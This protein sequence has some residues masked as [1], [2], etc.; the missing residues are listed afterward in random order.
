MTSTQKLLSNILKNRITAELKKEERDFTS[1]QGTID[2]FIAGDRI[3]LEQY[4]ELIELMATDWNNM[5]DNWD[6]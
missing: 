6:F 2:V 4:T 3:T 5:G 1:I